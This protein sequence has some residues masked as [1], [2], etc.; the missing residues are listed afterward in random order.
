[1]PLQLGQRVFAC[2]N[3][4]F[5]TRGA[6]MDDEPAGLTPHGN[7]WI[8]RNNRVVLSQWRVQLLEAIE[9]T[10]SISA[11][12]ERLGVQYRL[13]WERLEEMEEGL[14]VRLV[15]RHVGGAH[16]GGASVTP[17]G[18]DLIARFHAFAAALDEALRT[19]F[20]RHFSTA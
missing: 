4:Q 9:T 15:E 1:M 11:A 12:A 17:A 6:A 10:G 5:T 13:A 8:E 14:G 3:N 18:R 19:E 7:L 16:G 2:Q 20:S